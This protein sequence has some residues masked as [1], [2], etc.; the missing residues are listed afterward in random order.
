VGDNHNDTIADLV[1]DSGRFAA[2]GDEARSRESLRKARD[3]DAVSFE[4]ELSRR[5]WANESGGAEETRR[6]RESVLRRL[7]GVAVASPD[8]LDVWLAVTKYARQL[9]NHDAV[10][11]AT[12]SGLKR[13]T[14]SLELWLAR[15]HAQIALGQLDSAARSLR[16]CTL[17]APT[18][19]AVEALV[20]VHPLCAR[21]G[22]LLPA[23]GAEFCATCGADGP[24]RGAPVRS[25]RARSHSKF[26]IYFPRVRDVV[27]SAL[28]MPEHIKKRLTLDTLLKRHLKRSNAQCAKVLEAM[29]KE[30]GP[31]FDEPLFQAAV[32]GYLDVLIA[33]LIRAIDPRVDKTMTTD[34]RQRALRQNTRAE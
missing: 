21:C 1:N 32:V 30:F 31:A 24:G 5:A 8:R 13:D 6:R 16:Q 33:D 34:V 22:A 23:A 26:D 28:S 4:L 7:G 12:A 15:A 20:Q 9:G 14:Y 10:V 3:L 18:N 29:S 19:D 2:A 11:H 17:I 25:V 27:A